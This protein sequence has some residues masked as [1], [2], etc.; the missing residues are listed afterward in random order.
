MSMRPTMILSKTE[1]LVCTMYPVWQDNKT[2]ELWD[3]RAATELHEHQSGGAFIPPGHA[4]LSEQPLE[5]DFRN[6]IR[7]DD[8]G[9][10]RW[11]RDH[12]NTTRCDACHEL[13]TQFVTCD[14]AHFRSYRCEDH[15]VGA[16]FLT[17]PEFA[18]NRVTVEMLGQRVWLTYVDARLVQES[19]GQ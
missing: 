9:A 15:G 8:T 11:E 4:P 19:R 7:S 5:R 12:A 6:H 18:S 1:C 14:S 2:E 16:F 10:E 13:A 3:D 17:D